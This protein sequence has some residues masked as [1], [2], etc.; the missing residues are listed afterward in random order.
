MSLISLFIPV[1]NGESYLEETIDSITKQT[2]RDFEVLFVDDG[3]T[4]SSVRILRSAAEKDNR[5]KVFEKTHEGSVPFAWNFLLSSGYLTSPWTLYMSQDDLLHPNLLEDLIQIQRSS[6]A[7]AVI[8]SCHF[9]TDS[10]NDNI[11]ITLNKNNDMSY[12][13]NQ[14]C[15]SGHDAFELMFDYSIPGFALWDTTVIIECGMPTEAFNSDEGMQ[16]IWALN[17]KKVAFCSTPFYYRQ[18]KNSIG[19]GIK[20]HHFYSVLTEM[21]LLDVAKSEQ[22]DIWKIHKFQYNSLFWTLWLICYMRIKDSCFSKQVIDEIK[23]ILAHSYKF[24]ANDLPKPKTKKELILYW[25]AKIK[26]LRSVYKIIYSQYL[27]FK[28]S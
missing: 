4:D 13:A 17:C 16:R 6:G 27:C 28:Y 22:I 24:F 7:N 5:I 20:L 9:F 18:Q 1:Y 26:F 25:V 19:S 2:F 12:R 3:S 10:I 14:G 11:F 21:K 15:I 8:P 23:P